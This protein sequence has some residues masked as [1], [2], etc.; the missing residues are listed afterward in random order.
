MCRA[1]Q[2]SLRRR[3]VLSANSMSRVLIG[4]LGSTACSRHRLKNSTA[5]AKIFCQIWLGNL[6]KTNNSFSAV[7]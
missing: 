3:A 6:E 1:A 5:L 4:A 2:N 7:R